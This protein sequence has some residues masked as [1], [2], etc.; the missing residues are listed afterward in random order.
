MCEQAKTRLESGTE[1]EACCW[2][3]IRDWRIAGTFAVVINRHPAKVQSVK[4]FMGNR[5]WT[6]FKK[7]VNFMKNLILDF[8]KFPTTAPFYP[9]FRLLQDV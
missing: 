1:A 2:S 9:C 8:P 5:F 4:I 7:S 6:I 3:A